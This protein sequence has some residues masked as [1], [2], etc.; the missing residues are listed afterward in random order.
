[1]ERIHINGLEYELLS[2][3]R[4]GWNMEAFRKRFSE[5]LEKY[6]YVVGDWG[7][8]QLRLKGFFADDHTRATTETK[9]SYL[10]EYL[11]EFCNFGCAYFVL[12]K[13][14]S[15]KPARKE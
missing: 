10:Q 6:D 1:M 9:I 5:I 11:N 8:G 14:K 3:H 7:Y 13:V 12:R 15:A 4:N 2:N